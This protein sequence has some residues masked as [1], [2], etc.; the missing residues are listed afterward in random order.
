MSLQTLID[1]R[2]ISMYRLAKISGVSKTVII[3]ICSG[4]SSIEN[5]TVK[6]VYSIATVLGCSVED[7]LKSCSNFNLSPDSQ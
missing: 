1:A 6:T 4:K 5:C 3:D 7:L 2:G